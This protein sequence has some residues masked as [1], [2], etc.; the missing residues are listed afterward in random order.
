MGNS[1]AVWCR[2]GVGTGRGYLQDRCIVLL[3]ALLSRTRA[4]R[5]EAM[6]CWPAKA[7]NV[8]MMAASRC[9]MCVCRTRGLL[10]AN[11]APCNATLR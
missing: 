11:T 9:R 7:A 2:H 3:S 10:L 1:V 8:L 6:L 5:K 4:Q